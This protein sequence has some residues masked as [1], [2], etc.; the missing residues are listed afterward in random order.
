MPDPAVITPDWF[1]DSNYFSG[2]ALTDDMI[3]SAESALGV[4]LPDAYLNLL[5]VKNGGTPRQ[6]CFPTHEPTGWAEDHIQI[7][8]IHGLSGRNGIDADLGSRYMIEEWGYPDVGV[9]IG[10]TP[11]AGHEAVM[12][13]YSQCGEQGEPRVI[14][15]DTETADGEP[16]IVVLASDFAAFVRGFVDSAVFDVE[17]E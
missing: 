2:P 16:H 15:V 12:L 14:Y 6:N 5:R 8:V 4:K 13:D 11:S 10:Y 1:T 3:R 9:V 17:D 7:D